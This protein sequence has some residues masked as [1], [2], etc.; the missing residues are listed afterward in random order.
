M[1]LADKP[2]ATLLSREQV[3]GRRV[4]LVCGI[5]IRRKRM[6]GFHTPSEPMRM[7]AVEWPERGHEDS[8]GFDAGDMLRGQPRRLGGRTW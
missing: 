3:Q 6:A 7:A 2:L 5:R 8:G 1:R 4:S